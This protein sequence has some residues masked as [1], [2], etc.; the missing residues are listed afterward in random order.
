MLYNIKSLAQNAKAQEKKNPHGFP[1]GSLNTSW[2]VAH[3]TSL[4]CDI[5]ILF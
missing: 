2:K 5:S 4:H 3:Y 1:D